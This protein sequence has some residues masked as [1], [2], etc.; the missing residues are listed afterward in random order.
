MPSTPHSPL[1]RLPLEELQEHSKRIERDLDEA[2]RCYQ[3][4]M[5]VLSNLG[6]ENSKVK[7]ALAAKIAKQKN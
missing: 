2:R 7:S 4:I 3:Y 1:L 5:R 6:E